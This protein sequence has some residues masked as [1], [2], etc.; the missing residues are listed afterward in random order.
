MF[1]YII[2]NSAVVVHSAREWLMIL[3]VIVFHNGVNHGDYRL[4]TAD[5]ENYSGV[6]TSMC[7]A[8]IYIYII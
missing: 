4:I 5:V 7:T 8:H 6:I 1:H 2:L 3:I